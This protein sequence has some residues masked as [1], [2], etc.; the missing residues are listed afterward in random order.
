VRVWNGGRDVTLRAWTASATGRAISRATGERLE[1]GQV[2]VYPVNL[3][4]TRGEEVTC[5]ARGTQPD[6]TSDPVDLLAPGDN[7]RTER[8]F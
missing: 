2:A 8:T 7:E 1:P 3:P 6:G 4:M 5:Q